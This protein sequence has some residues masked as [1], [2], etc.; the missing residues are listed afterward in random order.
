MTTLIEDLLPQIKKAAKSVAYQWPGA[1]EQDDME[2]DI[3]VRLLEAEGVLQKLYNSEDKERLQALIWWGNQIAIKERA[4]YEVFS[5]NFRYSVNEVKRLLAGGMLRGQNPAT[6]SSWSAEDY[7]SGD[8]SFE[9]AVLTRYSTEMDLTRAMKVL[10]KRENG[11]AR[12]IIIRYL[13]KGEL[14]AAQRKTLSRAL[15]SL[16]DEMNRSF[17]RQ[18]VESPHGPGTRHAVS[19]ATAQRISAKQYSGGFD[20]SGAGWDTERAPYSKTNYGKP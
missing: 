11:Y 8:N 7:L 12:V 20:E 1:V 4:D 18:H 13:L 2:Q 15:K 3:I 17:K 14:D 10:A 5:G 16:T 6:G 9:D 19:N